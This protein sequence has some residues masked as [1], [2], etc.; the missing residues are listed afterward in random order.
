[1][2]FNVT[3]YQNNPTF[4]YFH[5]LQIGSTVWIKETLPKHKQ[6]N[7]PIYIQV[8]KSGAK[9]SHALDVNNCWRNTM[10][11]EMYSCKARNVRQISNYYNHFDSTICSSLR[12]AQT[13]LTSLFRFF[14]W[15]W[16][17]CWCVVSLAH[18]LMWGI[19]LYF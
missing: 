1:M 11:R 6:R 12:L 14:S 7:K 18:R 10:Y 8:S 4:D 3:R 13:Y 16:L 2:L 9:S 19:Y 5:L 17:I 15:W